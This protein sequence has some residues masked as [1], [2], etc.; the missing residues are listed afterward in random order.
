MNYLENVM[1]RESV[2]NWYFHQGPF[3]RFIPLG[4]SVRGICVGIPE[5]IG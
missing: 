5:F 3:L 2:E 1:T 4:L